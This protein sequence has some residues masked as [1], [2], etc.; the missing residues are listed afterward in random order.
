MSEGFR[1]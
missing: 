1:T